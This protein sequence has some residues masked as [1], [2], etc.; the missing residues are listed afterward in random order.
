MC[1]RLSLSIGSFTA[2]KIGAQRLC[3][4]GFPSIHFAR[5]GLGRLSGL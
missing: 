1:G 3:Q 4:A 2:A 5:F